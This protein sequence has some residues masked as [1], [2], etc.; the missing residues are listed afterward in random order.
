MTPYERITQETFTA[1]QEQ[2]GPIVQ[3]MTDAAKAFAQ[4]LKN[5]S[6]IF[7]QNELEKLAA[8]NRFSTMCHALTCI[9]PGFATAKGRLA[10]IKAI[11]DGKDPAL[12][13]HE[14]Y[15]IKER[16]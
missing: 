4:G 5:L 7:E 2:A 15:H 10:D 11:L 1:L 16:G 3:E 8:E 9:K 12:L 6:A 14:Q 13:T